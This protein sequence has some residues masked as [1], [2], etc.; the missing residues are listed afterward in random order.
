[1]NYRKPSSDG[2]IERRN[3]MN[4]PASSL[5]PRRNVSG[6]NQEE[7]EEGLFPLPPLFFSID[8]RRRR[9][10]TMEEEG[11][12]T[13]EGNSPTNVSQTPNSAASFAF[14]HYFF[15]KKDIV[16]LGNCRIPYQERGQLN[17]LLSY[18]TTL[19][20]RPANNVCDRCFPRFFFHPVFFSAISPLCS[21]FFRFRVFK[22]GSKCRNKN[23]LFLLC[24]VVKGD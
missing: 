3:I 9:L 24:A 8:K 1:M 18:S 20:P 5:A 17:F 23:L 14:F 15:A 11:V 12:C 16:P 7:E 13:G 4:P 2:V 22:G 19:D 21:V 6:T 10:F